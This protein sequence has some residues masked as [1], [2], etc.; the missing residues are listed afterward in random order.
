M[1]ILPIAPRRATRSMSSNLRRGKIPRLRLRCRNAVF[2]IIDTTPPAPC[3]Y[4]WMAGTAD[5][6]R[7]AYGY[8][9]AGRL[10]ERYDAYGTAEQARTRFEYNESRRS[11]ADDRPERP[12][13]QLC[14]MTMRAER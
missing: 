2:T 10:V 14:S 5:E 3:R 8:D 1:S 12:R 9:G 13:H 7:T 4:V 11:G 6:S